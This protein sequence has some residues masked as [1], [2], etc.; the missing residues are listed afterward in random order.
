MKILPNKNLTSVI[1][2][3]SDNELYNY[4]LNQNLSIFAI[5]GDDAKIL[6]PFD[7]RLIMSGS[8][9]ILGNY[10][11]IEDKESGRIITLGNL[12]SKK[13]ANYFL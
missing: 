10:V 12:A 13:F 3:I 6:S 9:E 4:A 2:K 1:A 8:S 7:G 11:M 5:N